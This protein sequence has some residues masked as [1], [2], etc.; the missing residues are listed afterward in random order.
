MSRKSSSNLARIGPQS[1][2]P[3][4][5]PP[6]PLRDAGRVLWQ[7]VLE[8]YEFSDAASYTTLALAGQCLDRAEGLREAIDRDGIVV[9]GKNGRMGNPL[10]RDENQARALC[11]R[12]LS[13]LGLDLE[14]VRP[15]RGRPPGVA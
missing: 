9:E 11:A 7:S 8:A 13:K 10:L 6:V 5:E 14:P 2:P 4:P 15:S 3:V 1:R 12:L